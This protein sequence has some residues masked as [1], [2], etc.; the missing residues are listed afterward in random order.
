[1]V[2]APEISTPEQSDPPAE[3][4]ELRAATLESFYDPAKTW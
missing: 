3:T 2:P 1:V 4:W